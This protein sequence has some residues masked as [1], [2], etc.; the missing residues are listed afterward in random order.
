MSKSIEQLRADY[1]DAVKDARAFD[2]DTNRIVGERAER[3]QALAKRQNRAGQALVTAEA[4][5]AAKPVE[6]PAPAPSDFEPLDA[7]AVDESK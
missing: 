3:R 2:A 6:P 5:A 4:K 7:S 1:E